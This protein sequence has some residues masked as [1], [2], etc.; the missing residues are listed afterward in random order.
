MNYN[1]NS[2][3]VKPPAMRPMD[4]YSIKSQIETISKLVPDALVNLGQVGNDHAMRLDELRNDLEDMRSL[5]MWI[6]EVHPDVIKQHL[7]LHAIERAGR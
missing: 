1:E 4:L 7:A 5:I 2:V 6:G 3:Y